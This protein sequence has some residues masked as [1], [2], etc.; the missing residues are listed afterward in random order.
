M[1]EAATVH[2]DGAARG[3]PGPAAWAYVLRRPG[4]PAEEVAGRLGTATCNVAEYTALV[5]ALTRA[6]ELGLPA[7]RVFSD[8]ELMVKQMAG[9]Y[10]VKH[11][12]LQPL[13]ARASALRDKLGAVTITHVRRA[14]NPDADRLC[15]SALDGKT[16]DPARPT[17]PA[18]PRR[19]PDAVE[20][21]GVALLNAVAASWAKHGPGHPPAVEVWDQ[22]VALVRSADRP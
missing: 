12:D 1:S 13:H 17:P 7:L 16:A 14:L 9:E 11:P 3:N 6:V 15:N 22:L 20:A 10:R 2:T 4:M 8:S 18:P 21:E 19:P 5:Q